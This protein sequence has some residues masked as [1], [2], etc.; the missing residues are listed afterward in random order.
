MEDTIDADDH[1][2]LEGRTREDTMIVIEKTTSH[3]YAIA[4]EAVTV[5]HIMAD[6]RIAQLSWKDYH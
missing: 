6:R 4:V 5:H 3:Q 2:H 1:V